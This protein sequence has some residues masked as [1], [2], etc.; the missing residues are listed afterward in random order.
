MQ[1]ADEVLLIRCTD[2]LGENRRVIHHV[3]VGNRWYPRHH[4]QGQQVQMHG[5]DG[6]S[7]QSFREKRLKEMQMEYLD[8]NDSRCYLKYVVKEFR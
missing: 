3:I 4:Y 5:E 8:N 1:L 7:H 6:V 2:P